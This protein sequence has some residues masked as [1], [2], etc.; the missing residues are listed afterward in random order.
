M[1][2]YIM[3]C[4]IECT[5]STPPILRYKWEKLEYIGEDG[6]EKSQQS[7]YFSTHWRANWSGNTL[8]EKGWK[9]NFHQKYIT[10]SSLKHWLK[11]PHPRL[12]STDNDLKPQLV[13]YQSMTKNW[14]SLFSGINVNHTWLCLFGGL[15]S[16]L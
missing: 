15:K 6:F 9:S 13:I 16:F 8:F 5:Y 3:V 1:E 12:L 4:K 10:L 2:F 14:F 11:T 7:P